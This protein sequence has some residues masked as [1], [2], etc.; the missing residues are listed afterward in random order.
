MCFGFPAN[1]HICGTW[2]SCNKRHCNNTH[3]TALSSEAEIKYLRSSCS[4]LVYQCDLIKWLRQLRQA[5]KGDEGLH[6]TL[7]RGR[8]SR[9]DG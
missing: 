2:D 9:E 8:I 4:R 6:T 1:R 5:E 3:D 7:G